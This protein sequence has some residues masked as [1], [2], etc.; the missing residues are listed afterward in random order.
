MSASSISA[1]DH[2][3]AHPAPHRQQCALD[4]AA[5]MILAIAAL[6][7]DARPAWP[8][9]R[10]E[11]S[12]RRDVL[13]KLEPAAAGLE[14]LGVEED[15]LSAEVGFAQRVE[16]DGVAAPIAAAVV[17]EDLER[18][19]VRLHRLRLPRTR[20]H[21]RPFSQRPPRAAESRVDRRAM[22]GDPST[23]HGARH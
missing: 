22:Q 19:T 18:G 1:G 6:G 11:R 9:Q 20:L 12:A 10:D 5:D 21:L 15:V 3:D 2:L 17:D 13:A 14:R 23:P 7:E 16:R 4:L 8:D